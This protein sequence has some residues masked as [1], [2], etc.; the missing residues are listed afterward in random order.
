VAR[1]LKF[2][3]RNCSEIRGLALLG[4]L[5]VFGLAANSRSVLHFLGSVG[6]AV[7]L[8]LIV[9]LGHRTLRR[10]R[11]RD[12]W[13][14][15]QLAWQAAVLIGWVAVMGAVVW[16]YRDSGDQQPRK[17]ALPAASDAVAPANRGD[18][19]P[20]AEVPQDAGMPP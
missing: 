2:S 1:R 12:P 3:P 14:A 20:P 6:F 9:V 11:H 13:T 15:G 8:L 18:A 10:A 5:V 16:W 17:P 7:T 4:G 19:G